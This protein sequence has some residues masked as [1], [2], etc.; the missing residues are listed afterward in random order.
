MPSPLQ[1][2]NG[3]GTVVPDNPRAWLVSAGR[4][5]AIDSIRRRA[6]FDATLDELAR[7]L[8]GNTPAEWDDESIEDDRLRLIFTCCHPALPPGCPDRADIARNVWPH[9]RGDRT[10]LSRPRAHDCQTH[11]ARQSQDPRRAHSL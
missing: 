7:Q 4:F 2:N 9:Y 3:R 5:K 10:G 1:W 11:R 8:D 6:R